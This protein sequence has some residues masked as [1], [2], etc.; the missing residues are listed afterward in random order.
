[1]PKQPPSQSVSRL[2][3]KAARARVHANRLVGD[4]AERRLKEL[5]DEIDQQ[6]AALGA[7]AGSSAQGT[8]A[9]TAIAQSTPT[10]STAAS[11]DALPTQQAVRM[12]DGGSELTHRIRERA[13][14]LWEAAGRPVG[15]DE[16]FWVEAET[17]IRT[18]PGASDK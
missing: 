12:S 7:S 1:M 13:Y 17:Q 8:E 6:A 18:E 2:R 9:P 16:Y 14:F 11:S 15:S 5:A 10:V 4:E 3:Q